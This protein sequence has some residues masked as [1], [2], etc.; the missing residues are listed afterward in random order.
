MLLLTVTAVVT[1]VSNA[2]LAA[3]AVI[4]NAAVVVQDV[5][6]ESGRAVL[7]WSCS[8]WSSSGMTTR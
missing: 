5:R 3:G 8:S 4:L 2:G 6:V 7:R 1:T